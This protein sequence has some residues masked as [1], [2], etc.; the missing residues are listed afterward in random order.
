MAMPP[1]RSSCWT[2][3]VV[4]LGKFRVEEVLQGWDA[5]LTAA[6]ERD[7]GLRFTGNAFWLEEADW[8]FPTMKR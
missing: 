4:R 8:G 7:Q 5:R 1:A 2:T 3:A 6:R